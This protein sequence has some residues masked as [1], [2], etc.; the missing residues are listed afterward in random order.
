MLKSKYFCVAICLFLG[1]SSVWAQSKTESDLFPDS[2]ELTLSDEQRADFQDKALRM[3][4][5]LGNYIGIIAD[6]SKP[7]VS[8]NKAIELAIKLFMSEENKV[9]VSSLRSSVIKEFPIRSYFNKLKLLTYS[10][11]AVTWYDIFFASQFT[12][13]PDGRY[14]AIATI[15]QRFEGRHKDGGYYRDVT[16]KSI[17][18]IIEQIEITKGTEVTKEWVVLLGDIKVEETK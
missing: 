5:S 12:K 14:E 6:K 3:T 2:E 10:K 18:I 13:R 7:D 9:Q 8:R 17:Q 11:V 1:Q 4:T 16:K 15:Y